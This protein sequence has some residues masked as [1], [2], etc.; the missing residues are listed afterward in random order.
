MCRCIFEK[1]WRGKNWYSGNHVK[2]LDEHLFDRKL[3]SIL[4]EQ[5]SIAWTARWA[6]EAIC[7]RGRRSL[8]EETSTSDRHI[9]LVLSL[10]LAFFPSIIQRSKIGLKTIIGTTKLI[11]KSP[12]VDLM[13]RSCCRIFLMWR[14]VLLTWPPRGWSLAVLLWKIFPQ[15]SGER[16]HEKL[17]SHFCSAAHVSTAV[18][19]SM[20]GRQVRM[21]GNGSLGGNLARCKKQWWDQESGRTVSRMREWECNRWIYNWLRFYACWLRRTLGCMRNLQKLGVFLNWCW[22]LAPKLD[23]CETFVSCKMSKVSR[24]AT[25]ELQL[26]IFAAV[27]I[28]LY[29]KMQKLAAFL[30]PGNIDPNFRNIWHTWILWSN[31]TQSHS[32]WQ[33]P[34]SQSEVI[35]AKLFKFKE[36]WQLHKTGSG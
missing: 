32:P 28:C 30:S 25:V 14:C 23:I 31:K 34:L 17:C 18:S 7:Q 26:A 1:L 21:H 8:Q 27:K 19:C 12:I 20:D 22:L 16:M 36:K 2:I 33:T 3:E 9:S 15:S 10:E 24:S 5:K 4:K 11:F 6:T 35:W 13:N 29:G